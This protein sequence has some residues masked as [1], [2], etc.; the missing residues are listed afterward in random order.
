[1]PGGYMPTLETKQRECWKFWDSRCEFRVWFASQCATFQDLFKEPKV[2]HTAKLTRQNSPAR[3]K[4]KYNKWQNKLTG[5]REAND[6]TVILFYLLSSLRDWAAAITGTTVWRLQHR[7]IASRING[8]PVSF[9]PLH[10]VCFFYLF[11]NRGFPRD[12]QDETFVS[13][14]WTPRKKKR[15]QTLVNHG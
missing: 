14:S 10:F 3:E 2:G 12:R 6:Q 9:A 15:R 5:Q 1:M 7:S 13:D 8:F 4:G 11:S